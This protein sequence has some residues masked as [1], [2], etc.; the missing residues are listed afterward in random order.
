MK[1]KDAP[2]K[3]CVLVC[4]GKDCKKAGSGKVRKSLEEAFDKAKLRVEVFKTGCQGRCSRAPVAL[5][6][7]QGKACM[8]LSPG[9]AGEI[10]EMMGG[11]GKKRED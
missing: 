1:I 5:L 3:G 8:E 4:N 10:V 9:D 2:G 11:K 6:W 7:P